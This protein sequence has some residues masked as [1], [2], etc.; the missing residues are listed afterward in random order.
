MDN[1]HFE[2]S[3]LPDFRDQISG[4]MNRYS[5]NES[6]P[7]TNAKLAY[8]PIQKS[9]PTAT[10]HHRLYF[11]RSGILP[12]FRSSRFNAFVYSTVRAAERTASTV[13]FDQGDR[14]TR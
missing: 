13:S 7:E 1:P 2:A 10:L 5:L 6:V 12:G 3:K 11:R 8:A 4:K 14:E 9:A